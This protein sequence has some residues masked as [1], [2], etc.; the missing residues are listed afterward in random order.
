[1]ANLKINQSELIS[2]LADRAEFVSKADAARFVAALEES[3]TER[4]HADHEARL[5]GIGVFRLQWVEPRKSVDVRTGNQIEI[6]GH[7]KLAFV[8]DAALKNSVNSVAIDDDEE[9]NEPLQKLSEQAAEINALLADI[10]G[11][12]EAPAEPESEPQPAENEEESVPS[13]SDVTPEPE[14]V[15]VVEPEPILE[16]EPE[17]EP[18]PVAPQPSPTTQDNIDILIKVK[19]N[20]ME[21]DQT[22]QPKRRSHAWIWILIVVLLLCGGVAAWYFCGDVIRTWTEARWQTVSTWC[23]DTWNGWFGSDEQEPA[24]EVEVAAEESDE[25]ENIF[26]QPRTYDEFIGNATIKKGVHLAIIAEQNYGHKDFWVYI[27][28][29][30][31]DVLTNPNEVEVGTKLRLPKMDERLVDASNPDAVAFA[32]QLADQYLQK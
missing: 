19:D 27:Y 29:A 21:K 26:A 12:D 31:R 9:K 1:M 14:P 28:E 2:R 32:Q 5:G 7:Y 16:P 25:E 15:P 17:P 22:E 20:K 10:N 11:A 30:N 23:S 18:A 24:E 4:L 3:F 6:A 8:P 13:E